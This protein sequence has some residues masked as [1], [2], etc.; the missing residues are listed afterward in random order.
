[1][2]EIHD[3]HKAYRQGK[4][5]VRALRG[6]SLRIEAGE[7][8]AIMGPSGSGKSTLM[9][10]LGLLD[11]PDR[12][13]YRLQGRDVSQLDDRALAK[14]R[15]GTIGFVFQQFNLLPRATARENVALPRIYND[16]PPAT[17]VEIYLQ[18][19]GLED[20][21]H[22]TPGELSGGQQ[23]RVA[24]ARA[25]VNNPKI[26][27]ADE[28]TGNLDSTSAAGIM[29]LLAELNRTGLTVIVVTHDRE[30]ARNADRIVT[31]R[32]GMI[33]DDTS[34]PRDEQVRSEPSPEIDTARR[35]QVLA[36]LRRKGIE[37]VSLLKQAL[38][39]LAANKTRTFLSMLGVLIGVA[40]VIAVLA[41]GMG[42]KIAVEERVS[43]MGANLLV[44]RPGRW[45]ARGIALERGA[46]SRLMV[47]DAAAIRE[48]FPEIVKVAPV[49][50]TWAQITAGGKNWRTT[51]IGTTPDY[52]Q[53]HDLVPTF[54][55][56]F[57]E[58]EMIEHARV[59]IIG[60]TVSRE[61]FGEE[62]PIGASLRI[63]RL[64][65]TV[66]GILPDKGEWFHMDQNDQIIIPCST[67][68][69]RLM[70]TRYLHS[71]ELQVVSADRIATM[72]EEIKM[73]MLKRHRITPPENEEPFRVRNVAEIQDM[74]ASTSRT[75]SVLLAGIGVIALLVGGIGIMNIMLV[76][77]TER[78]REIGLRKAVGARRS[79][80]L[81]QF[82]VES[83]VVSVIGGVIGIGLGWA[84][85]L[86]MSRTAGWTVSVSRNAV[87]IAFAFS[88]AVG[89]VFGLWP[90]QKASRLAPIDALR[91][92]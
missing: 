43:S 88:A 65:F 11:R 50:R 40:S 13:A 31:T 41:L 71:I 1:M 59:A 57:R 26:L 24:I 55:R 42:A 21:G 87:L 12:G 67:A 14:L 2:I 90:A 49:A 34:K 62:N 75:M 30:V 69:R 23:Q 86:L 77:V 39:S 63:N 45:R 76:S 6:V 80:I 33:T 73:F 70:G 72:E 20:R 56:M 46:V 29:A 27:L 9:H 92:E 52:V 10:I 5:D 54:G 44:L 58:P 15:A 16:Q 91:S 4:M 32:D 89:V 61:L 47:D 17:P 68:L 60:L 85:S 8:V 53:M 82:L 74:I 28:P 7:F 3:I 35:P 81:A 25:L 18:R 48:S 78:T 79:D 22:H 66:I 37:A 84:A 19:V 38:R 83:V 64:S 36:G 51:I